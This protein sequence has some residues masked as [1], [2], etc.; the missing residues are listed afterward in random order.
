ML[1]REGRRKAQAGGD[2]VAHPVENTPRR[3]TG[4]PAPQNIDALQKRQAGADQRGELPGE[5]KQ[6]G[7]SD[8]ASGEE[9]GH[10]TTPDVQSEVDRFMQARRQ[11]RRDIGNYV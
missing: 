3:R 1:L 7:G 11:I 8:V 4:S 6:V 2:S 9:P 5:Q 10:V